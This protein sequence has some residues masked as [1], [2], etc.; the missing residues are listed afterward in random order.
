MHIKAGP[1]FATTLS[2]A[3][4]RITSLITSK[5][6]DFFDLS[7]YEWTPK[8]KEDSPSM[9]LYELINWLTTVVDGLPVK[10][11]YKVEAYQ[12]AVQYIADCLTVCFINSL[13]CYARLNPSRN[14]WLDAK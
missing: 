3:A 13:V 12:A 8:R 14:S 9:Y 11:T 4:A 1:S 6:D 7:E 5:L 10:D 2:H